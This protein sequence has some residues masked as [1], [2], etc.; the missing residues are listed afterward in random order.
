MTFMLFD[1]YADMRNE[2]AVKSA[3]IIN[4]LTMSCV[5]TCFSGLY[6]CRLRSD[7]VYA[8]VSPAAGA[9]A[10]VAAAAAAAAAAGG[11]RA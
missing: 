4:F 8:T 10:A 7:T 9:A 3:A 2:T 11:D 5:Q 1:T 6:R